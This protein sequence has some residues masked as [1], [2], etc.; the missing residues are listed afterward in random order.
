M[1]SAEP[2]TM[3]VLLVEDSPTDALLTQA[4]IAES[5][6]ATALDRVADGVEAMAFLRGEGRYRNAHR[7]DLVLLDL[8]L[9]RRNGHEVLADIKTD[10]ALQSIPVVVLTTSSAEQDVLTAYRLHA[11]CYITKPVGFDRFEHVIRSVQEFWFRTVTLPV[12]D[13]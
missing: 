1:S 9:P 11:N 4:A 6:V 3:R 10:P 2:R 8:N 5:G 12:V 7:P 13:R